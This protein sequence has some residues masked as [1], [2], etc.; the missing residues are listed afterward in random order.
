MLTLING[1]VFFQ[2]VHNECD[3]SAYKLVQCIEF[4][5]GSA[6][7]DDQ[8]VSSHIA[9][10]K[11]QAFPDVYGLIVTKYKIATQTA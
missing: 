4:L 5:F 1:V 3:I 6:V 8:G 9:E 11:T 7:T 2:N 10:H